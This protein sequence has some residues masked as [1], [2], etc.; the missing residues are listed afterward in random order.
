MLTWNAA[1]A[2][3]GEAIDV[4]TTDSDVRINKKNGLYVGVSGDLN[5]ILKNDIDKPILFK[6]VPVGFIPLDV[7]QVLTADT[8]AEDII[9][10]G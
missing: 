4:S 3:T 6:N 10:L 5:V 1:I 8:T 2:G 7:R 9:I